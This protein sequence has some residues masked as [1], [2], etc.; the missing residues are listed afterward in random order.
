MSNDGKAWLKTD[1]GENKPG[2]T[3]KDVSKPKQPRPLN[4]DDLKEDEKLHG[5]V[6]EDH[7]FPSKGN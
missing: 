1:S 4:S 2:Q 6:D 7:P 3:G 5:L